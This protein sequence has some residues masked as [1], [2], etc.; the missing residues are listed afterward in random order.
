MACYPSFPESQP[1]GKLSAH[2]CGCP[3]PWQWGWRVKAN[4]VAPD[5]DAYL[6][7]G[8]SVLLVIPRLLL[9]CLRASP[10]YGA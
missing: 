9:V 2:P 5:M 4:S 7:D 10:M 3:S 8:A 6:E 1:P